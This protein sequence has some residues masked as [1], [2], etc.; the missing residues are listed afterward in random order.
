MRR[1]LSVMKGREFHDAIAALPGYAV[2]AAG[3]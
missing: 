1:Q 2:T 3:S